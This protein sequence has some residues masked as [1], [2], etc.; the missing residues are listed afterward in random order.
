MELVSGTAGLRM[1]TE[2]LAP[3]AH[4]WSGAPA[5]VL[6]GKAMSVKPSPK[7][8]PLFETDSEDPDQACEEGEDDG[9][10]TVTAPSGGGDLSR[11]LRAGLARGGKSRV[12]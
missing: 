3:P 9:D 10:E 2:T 6:T 1:R 5:P 8:L 7:A 11:R 4:D 12:K